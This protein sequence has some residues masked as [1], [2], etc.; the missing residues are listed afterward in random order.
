MAQELE[1]LLKAKNLSDDAFKA[2]EKHLKDLE[3]GAKKA[4]GR[5]DKLAGTAR[6]VGGKMRSAGRAMLPFTAAISGVGIAAVKLASDFESSFAGVRKT[7]DATEEQFAELADGFRKMSTEIPISV[8]EL[9][10]IGEA[11]GQ[12]GIKTENIVTFTKTMAELGITTNLSAEEAA[13]SLARLA[14]ITQMPQSSF[15][16]LGAT[17]VE[18]GNN[19]ATTEAEIVEMGLRL[20]GAGKQIGLT[21]PQILAFG[22][23]LSSVGI[24]AEAGGSA[25]SKLMINMATAVS[26][27]GAEL[28]KF[29]KTAGMSAET[30]AIRFK[31]DA[32]GAIEAFVSGL[33]EIQTSGGDTLAVLADLGVT[34]MRM[35]DAL[36]RAS[37]AGDLL[38]RSLES[39]SG[40]WSENSALTE[41]A[42]KRYETFASQLTLFWN[43]VKDVGITI[44]TELL[45]V[46]RDMLAIV[47]ADVIPAIKSLAGWF[48][49]LSPTMQK[50]VLGVA[51]FVAAVGPLL[52][53]LGSLVTGLGTLLP[54]FAAAGPAVA[55]ATAALG[56]FAAIIAAIAG[57]AALGLW[58]RENSE[59]FRSFTDTVGDAAAGIFEFFTQAEKGTD[60]TDTWTDAQ[61]RSL[62]QFKAM[63]RELINTADATKE[64]TAAFADM[65]EKV[66]GNSYVP[67]MLTSIERE[68][69]RLGDVMVG[70]VMNAVNG[71]LDH[72]KGLADG[73]GGIWGDLLSGLTGMVGSWLGGPLAGLIAKGISAIGGL[74]GDLFGGKSEVSKARDAFFNQFQDGFVGVQRALVGTLG[75]VENQDWVKQLFDAKTVE[76]FNAIVEK[77][78]ATIGEIPKNITVTTTYRET[79]RPPQGGQPGRPSG[80]R[81]GGIVLPFRPRAA[82]EG[83][84]IQARPGGELVRMG[85]GGK[86]ELAVP[87]DALLSRMTETAVRA[88]GAGGGEQRVVIELEGRQVAEALIRRNR[89]G[90]M[91]VQQSSLRRY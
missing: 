44:G 77:I 76:E 85:E 15:D 30:F 41:E 36:L 13:T 64:T 53:V 29:A 33:G 21:E 49:G 11:A 20:A 56:P 19:F 7:V 42:Q 10:R 40:A 78:L 9:N 61:K 48:S 1:L 67:D 45:P 70:P 88:A 62:E 52:V 32:A 72:F 68:F 71:V 25:I 86:A 5:F 63:Q 12:L 26:A 35:R 65:H 69:G 50:V 82:A 31:Q 57:G 51:A 8:N 54:L 79:G 47:N 58:L 81:H 83:A 91:P 24:K 23:A 2:V 38:A 27:G 74:I 18:L 34:E 6:N 46:L 3:G 90:L 16:R 37:G 66:V 89:A 14:N 84:V 87:I 4:E 60:V 55:G 17:V 22:A 80:L 43:Q 59:L 73:I 39:A 28:E 75:Q